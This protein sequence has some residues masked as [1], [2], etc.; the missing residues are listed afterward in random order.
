MSD[1]GKLSVHSAAKYLDMTP[2][3]FTRW[4]KQ[5]GVRFELLGPRLRRYAKADLDKAARAITLRIQQ[6][7][8]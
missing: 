6:G 5:E 8:A 7:A 1:D 4:V 2:R 3:Q